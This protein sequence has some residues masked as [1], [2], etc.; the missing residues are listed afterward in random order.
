MT[1]SQKSRQ[2]AVP[3]AKPKPSSASSKSASPPKRKPRSKSGASV[4]GAELEKRL[5]E[6]SQRVT[7]L[8]QII[9]GNGHR[10]EV[11]GAF[12]ADLAE[13]LAVLSESFSVVQWWPLVGGQVGIEVSDSSF[14]SLNWFQRQKL[15][16]PVLA[17]LSQRAFF[18]VIECQ[19]RDSS[20]TA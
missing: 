13:I 16:D 3:K 7:E 5:S 9:E 17:R 8:E 15:I 4:A 11:D 2:I 6:L 12:R 10:L 19:S 20:E 14:R 1:V 18:R